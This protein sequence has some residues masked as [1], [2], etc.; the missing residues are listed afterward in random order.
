MSEIA[1]AA[2]R[3]EFDDVIALTESAIPKANEAGLGLLA[4]E[5]HGQRGL[6][7]LQR[8]SVNRAQDLEAA[9]EA[10]EAAIAL[11]VTGEQTANLLMHLALVY[12]DRVR[13]DRAENLERAVGLLR[14]A[15][16][17]LDP[18]R[19]PELE[20]MMRT[21]LAVALMR[22]E[23]GDRVANLREAA[24]LCRAALEYRSAERDAGDWAHSQLNLGEALEALAAL[25]EADVA[26][27]GRA[28]ERVIEEEQHLRDRWLVGSAHHA[29]GRFTFVL[30][31][32]APKRSSML[33]RKT[34]EIASRRTNHS[35]KQH[36]TIF[37]W[38]VN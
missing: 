38:L 4:C 1:A 19:T 25:G 34:N 24:Q 30:L 20:A 3:R 27:A 2:E 14:A 15:L 5:L 7:F 6:A 11:A 35:S 16:D 33:M 22:R 26:H 28:Y 10:H 21:N 9:I 13:G 8:T 12:A 29:L 32:R 23:R 37:R 36:A 31:M 18:P 17:E